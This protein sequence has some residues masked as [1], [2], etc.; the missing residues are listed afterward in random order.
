[1]L[2]RLILVTSIAVVLMGCSKELQNI[3]LPPE[4]VILSGFQF[5]AETEEPLLL[6][7]S[8]IG[9]ISPVNCFLGYSSRLD[10]VLKRNIV[11]FNFLQCGDQ[12]RE[13]NG[14]A[15]GNDNIYGLRV[16]PEDNSVLKEDRI[17]T[18]EVTDNLSLGG[19]SLQYFGDNSP[20][21]F[22]ANSK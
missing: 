9:G 8:E 17:F 11:K 22:S 5:Y 6:K 15:V 3:K 10:Y 7:V 16:N 12:V 4:A 1:M 13:F 18:V 21:Y 2:N 14:I 20:I 19:L